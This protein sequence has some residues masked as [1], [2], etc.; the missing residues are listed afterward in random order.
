MHVQWGLLQNSEWGRRVRGYMVRTLHRSNRQ[1][2]RT[3]NYPAH[4]IV[5]W[6]RQQ[7][8]AICINHKSVLIYPETTYRMTT[9]KMTSSQY[10]HNKPDLRSLFETFSWIL[11]WTQSELKQ[12]VTLIGVHL[13]GKCALCTIPT[14]QCRTLTGYTVIVWKRIN[15]Y[16]R[17]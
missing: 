4:C 5:V 16:M 12:L 14:V 8:T 11:Y 15:S 3:V 6:I 10:K 17:N 2:D 7:Q 9:Q 1:T 13:C